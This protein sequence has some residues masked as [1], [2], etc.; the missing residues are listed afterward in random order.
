[1]VVYLFHTL[2]LFIS[3]V[4]EGVCFR[5]IF[6]FNS[7]PYKEKEVKIPFRRKDSPESPDPGRTYLPK[8]RRMTKIDYEDLSLKKSLLEAQARLVLVRTI[9]RTFERN[10]SEQYSRWEIFLNYLGTLSEG[11]YSPVEFRIDEKSNTG[12][13]QFSFL[14]QNPPRNNSNMKA[15]SNKG[16]HSKWITFSE[17]PSNI[18]KNWKNLSLEEQELLRKG[19]SE[20][21]HLGRSIDI[22]QDYEDL[23]FLEIE[24][25][26]DSNLL[27]RIPPPSLYE[28]ENGIR[29]LPEE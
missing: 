13:T 2:V 28:V 25:P 18:F 7:I 6:I 22:P 20:Y 12:K 15:L 21:D 14:I 5:E 27:K 4:L 26:D 3:L 24:I 29:E 9:Q 16:L 1:V 8:S 11:S 19:F 17:D 10:I 23:E